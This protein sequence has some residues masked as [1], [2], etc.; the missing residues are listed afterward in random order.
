M[1]KQFSDERQELDQTV[2]EVSKELKLKLLIVENF[3]PRDVTERIKERAEWN[4]DD[5]TWNV[6][7]WQSTSSATAASPVN[8]FEVNEDVVLIRSSGADSGV[9]VSGGNTPTTA[10]FLDKRL[11]SFGERKR[12]SIRHA[13]DG[14]HYTNCRRLLT[15]KGEREK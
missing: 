15:R 5:F 1:S 12:D 9:S 3:I 2:T 7:S 8:A 14:K 6:N 13:F 11:V 10:Q 4:E